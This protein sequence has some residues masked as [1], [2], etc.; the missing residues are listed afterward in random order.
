LPKRVFLAYSSLKCIWFV[1]S[2]SSV[3]HW[4]SVSVMV[5]AEP[6]LED[7]ADVQV[8]EEP[9]LPDLRRDRAVDRHG[10]LLSPWKR[11]AA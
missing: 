11:R 3:N 6:A 1:F 2:V 8:L 5:P 4:L 9:A 7:V 10:G